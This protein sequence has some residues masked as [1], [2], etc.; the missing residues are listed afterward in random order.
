MDG[1]QGQTRWPREQCL[2]TEVYPDADRLA[3]L[4]L[5]RPGLAL[6]IVQALP[7]RKQLRGVKVLTGF[8]LQLVLQTL[9]LAEE[10]EGCVC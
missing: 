9:V 8:V 5:L 4:R 2:L 7:P 3:L 6:L 1:E 10:H